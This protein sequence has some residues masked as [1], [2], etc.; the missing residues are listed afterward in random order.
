MNAVIYTDG[1]SR[2]NPG[3]AGIGAVITCG[4]KEFEISEYIGQTTNNVAEYKA[5]IAALKKARAVKDSDGIDITDIEIMLDSEL[6]ERQLKGMYKVKMPHLQVLY[7]EV[8]G[9][10]SGFKSYKVRHVLR[11]HNAKADCLANKALNKRAG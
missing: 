3:H 9:L 11:H 7:N 10:L 1:A 8:K 4:E 5:L 2:G 6:V